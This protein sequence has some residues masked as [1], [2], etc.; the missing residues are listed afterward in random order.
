M[1]DDIPKTINVELIDYIDRI[2]NKIQ[3]SMDGK[4]EIWQLGL[5]ALR[6]EWELEHRSLVQR[7]E[8]SEAAKALA[9]IEVDRHFEAQNNMQNRMDKL[10]DTFVT[11]KEFKDTIDGLKTWLTGCL[12]SLVF[13][14][15][16]VVV[17][18][19]RKS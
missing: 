8:A 16:A 10:S 18:L 3:C 5:S 4:C 13:L 9:K 17:D 1:P 7:Y 15:I 11:K 12:V 2:T 19:I 14:L 6:K